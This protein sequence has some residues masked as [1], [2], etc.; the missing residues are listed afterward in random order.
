[1]S[2]I[3]MLIHEVVAS[4]RSP[5]MVGWKLSIWDCF[6]IWV[7]SHEF[8]GLIKSSLEICTLSELSLA[9][10]R[11]VCLSKHDW[12]ITMVTIFAVSLLILANISLPSKVHV[13]NCRNEQVSFI[14]WYVF[15]MSIVSLMGRSCTQ[16]YVLL[17][18]W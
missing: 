10:V 9:C 3:S 6:S 17:I 7:L 12:L 14:G 16:E 15:Q 13:I 5:V 8:L 1:M 2:L 4:N 18:W 11:V